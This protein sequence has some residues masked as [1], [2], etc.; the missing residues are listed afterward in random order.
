MSV[1]PLGVG[2]WAVVFMAAFLGAEDALGKMRRIRRLSGGSSSRN[3]FLIDQ[4]V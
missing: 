4:K 2:H 1:K 3:G